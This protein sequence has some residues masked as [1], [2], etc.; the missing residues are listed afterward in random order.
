MSLPAIKVEGLWKEYTVGAARQHHGTFYD[1]LAHSIKAPFSRLSK[2]GGPPDASDQF[3]A[4]R[5]INF[6]IQPG[7][8]VG[9]IGRNGA[10]KSTLLKMLSR[11]TAP[12]RGRIEVRGRLA[13]LLEVGTGFHPEL[14][15]RENIYLNGA[16]LGM[17]RNEVARKFDEIVAFAE[18]E[19]FIDTPVKRY[20]SGMYVRL[21]FA[22]AASLEVDVLVVDEVL[23]VGD[24]AFQEKCMARMGDL[25][26]GGRTILFVSHNL[27]AVSRLCSRALVMNA[28]TLAFDGSASDGLTRYSALARETGQVHTTACTGPLVGKAHLVSFSVN[29]SDE[30]V[31]NVIKPDHEIN[32]KLTGEILVP[33][34]DFRVTIC[35]FKNDQLVLGMH[36]A[37]SPSDMAPGIFDSEFHVPN[38]FLSPGEYSIDINMYSNENGQWMIAKSFSLF[39]ISTEWHPLYEPTHGMGVVNLRKSGRRLIRA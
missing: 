24:T 4:L 19:K 31:G 11:I 18:V 30:L 17:S 2:L 3:W 21:A 25:S 20:S 22:V 33:L 15:G 34:K 14:S 27:G 12:T 26:T 36:D 5:D 8:V 7:D 16:I 28:G 38:F 6:E 37:E 23:A 39:S 13:S 1:L 35:I 32:L 29:G 10:G 9:V